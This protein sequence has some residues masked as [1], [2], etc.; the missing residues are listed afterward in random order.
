MARYIASLIEELA[1]LKIPTPVAKP[2]RLMR[3]DKP[4]VGWFKVNTDGGF[5]ALENAGRAGVVIRDNNGKVTAAAA[6]WLDDVQDALMAEAISAK[7]G[8]ELAVEIGYVYVVL[9]IDCRQLFLLLQDPSNARSSIGGLCVDIG[10]LC[11]SFRGFKIAWVGREANV[12]ADHCANLVSA[13][14][15]FFIWRDCIPEWLEMLASAD[16]NPAVE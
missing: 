16:C 15:R 3:W 6:R 14:E 10:E 2:R 12:V 13:T 8:L 7:E 9:E 5:V 1:T 11:K 4:E